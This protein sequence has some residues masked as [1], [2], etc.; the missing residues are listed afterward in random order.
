MTR[1]LACVAGVSSRGS[2]RKLGQEQKKNNFR[3]ITRLETLA[4]QATRDLSAGREGVAL[5]ATVE[6]KRL[7]EK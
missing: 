5:Q 1:D 3:V 6:N 2:S 4:T 7:Y